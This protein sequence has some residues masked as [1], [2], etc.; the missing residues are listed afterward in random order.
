MFKLRQ[1]SMASFAVLVV[2]ACASDEPE[3]VLVAVHEN[4]VKT[5]PAGDGYK[6]CIE[7]G[8]ERQRIDRRTF[9]GSQL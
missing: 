2:S 5:A 8:R 6:D 1:I 4:C 3:A 7:L 9:R